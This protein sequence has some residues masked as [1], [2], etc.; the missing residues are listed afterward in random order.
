MDVF[1]LIEA[2]VQQ[3]LMA[4]DTP[5]YLSIAGAQG[6]G[7]TT[8][9][10]RLRAYFTALGFA[11]V[12]FSIDDLYLTRA[13]RMDCAQKIHP[14]LRTRGVPGTH[15]LELGFKLLD[16]LHHADPATETHLPA[17]DKSRDDRYPQ[18]LWP[19]CQGRPRLIICEGWCMGATPQ[20]AA[21]LAVPVNR[22]EETQD[23]DGRW[24]TWVNRRLRGPY[25]R[26]FDRFQ[27]HLFL[28]APGFEVVCD[29]RHEQERGL[30]ETQTKAGTALMDRAAVQHFIQ[31]YE[32]LTR[33]MLKTMPQSADM[34]LYLKKDRTPD[35]LSIKGIRSN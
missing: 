23:P 26:W 14:L 22:L 21:A 17:F 15:D 35:R 13:E 6:S 33:H 30:A 24:R 19:T 31:H 25:R 10:A 12:A 2:A 18:Q 28:A 5:L 20:S 3:R 34:T 32:R 11:T 27:L 4:Q 16:Q 9:A 8:L 7:K 29:W 1:P